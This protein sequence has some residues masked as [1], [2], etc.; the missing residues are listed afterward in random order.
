MAVAQEPENPA[1]QESYNIAAVQVLCVLDEQSRHPKL[2][3]M[4]HIKH[5]STHA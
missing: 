2:S 5:P 4:P 1:A 3:L